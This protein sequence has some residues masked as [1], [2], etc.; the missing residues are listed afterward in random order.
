M[1]ILVALDG[2]KPGEEAVKVIAPWARSAGAEVTLL[3]V[4]DPERVHDTFYPSGHAHALTPRGTASGTTVRGVAEPPPRAAEDRTQA[5]ERVRIEAEEY[6][7][8]QADE[9]L[10]DATSRVH[11][12]WAAEAAP[13]IADY[14]ET[15]GAHVIAIGTHGRSGLTNVLLGSV[16]QAVIRL[17]KVPV[18]VVREGM[19]VPEAAAFD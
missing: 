16:A 2:S 8:R 5:L 10:K 4:V 6:L 1:R 14:A 12:E 13:S 17:S 9:L 3:T 7:Q 18:L 19:R 11:V 15:W